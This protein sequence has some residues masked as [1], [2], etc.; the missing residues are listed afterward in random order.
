MRCDKRDDRDSK[1]QKMHF[2]LLLQPIDDTYCAFSLH[3]TVS[4]NPKQAEANN[5]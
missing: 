3:G 5:E 4:R 1:N 2:T